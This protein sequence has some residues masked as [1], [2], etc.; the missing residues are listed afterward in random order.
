MSRFV[1]MAR[2]A[3]AAAIL[4]I[5]GSGQAAQVGSAQQ[6]LRL[7]R[8]ICSEC[9]LV[10]KEA[11]RSNNP[12]AP[13]FVAIAN[14]PGLTAATLASALQTSHKAMPNVILKGD[15]LSD[16]IAYILSLRD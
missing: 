9:H 7:A 3:P 1:G 6:G 16:I 8:A 12:A 15:D 13:T 11:G 2:V 4:A 14:T 5:A 10:V